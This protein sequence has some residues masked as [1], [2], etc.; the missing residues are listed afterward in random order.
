MFKGA[1][2]WRDSCTRTIIAFGLYCRRLP[3][4]HLN[5]MVIEHVSNVDKF[6]RHSVRMRYTKLN[7]LLV[8][9]PVF[10]LSRSV[11][12]RAKHKHGTIARC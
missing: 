10:L 11:V 6:P 9:T 3:L 8:Q 12:P 4:D 7:P 5:Q 2:A 1:L